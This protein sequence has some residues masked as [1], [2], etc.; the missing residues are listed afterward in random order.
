MT[1][2][3]PDDHLE[4]G[5]IPAGAGFEMIMPSTWRMLELD[6]ARRDRSIQSMLRDTLGRADQLA[7]L[8]REALNAYRRALAGAARMGGFFAATYAENVE[9][10]PLTASLLAFLGMMPLDEAGRPV[11]LDTTLEGLATPS[12][13]EEILDAPTLVGDLR[14]GPGVRV[15]ARVTGDVGGAGGRRPPVDVVR[16][17]VPVPD[18]DRMLVMAFSTPMLYASDAFASVFDHMAA[19]ARWRR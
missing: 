18:W 7:E 19:S 12:G 14:V 13:G 16:F 15:R 3:R 9:G 4:P 11:D 8:R 5:A 6:P 10:K 1:S 17:F 2:P